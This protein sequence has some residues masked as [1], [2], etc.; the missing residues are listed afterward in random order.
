MSS[1]WSTTLAQSEFSFLIRRMGAPVPMGMDD[2]LEGLDPPQVLDRLACD[3][4]D[5]DAGS[6]PEVRS[7]LV[8]VGAVPVLLVGG[9]SAARAVIVIKARTEAG[10]AMRTL[11]ISKQLLV[12]M[13][14]GEGDRVTLTAVRDQRELA[15]RTQVFAGLGAMPEGPGAPMDLAQAD[16]REAQIL[17][18]GGS[19]TGC[20]QTLRV[21]DVPEATVAA[22]AQALGQEGTFGSLTALEVDDAGL[23][24]SAT[25]GW[26]AGSA[27]CWVTEPR[28]P[29]ECGVV[30]LTPAAAPDIERR[31]GAMVLRYCQED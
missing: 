15:A 20:E 4:Y 11:Y 21:A 6:H 1:T 24:L 27:G 23:R 14:A 9:M 22:L 12:E 7:G 3:Q 10:V 29:H 13:E 18:L 8:T 30:G 16:L 28:S 31:L 25:L 2:P 17:A 26:L 5:E 19:V